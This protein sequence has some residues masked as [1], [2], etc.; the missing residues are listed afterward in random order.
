MAWKSCQKSAVPV[1]C[2]NNKTLF[3][4][5]SVCRGGSGWDYWFCRVIRHVIL[6]GWKY[7]RTGAVAEH[8]NKKKTEEKEHQQTFK[9]VVGAADVDTK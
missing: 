7:E 3:T 5:T 9:S 6:N 1:R 4:C 8:Q 2:G